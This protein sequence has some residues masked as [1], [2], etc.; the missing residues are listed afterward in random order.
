MTSIRRLEIRVD[1]TGSAKAGIRSIAGSV[2]SIARVGMV[3][4]AAAIGGVA[5]LSGAVLGLGSRLTKLGGSAEEMQAKFDVV[6]GESAP[7]ATRQLNAFGFAVGRNKFAL[8]GMASTLQDTFVPLGFAREKA[9]DMSVAVTKLA[10]DVG[11][12]NNTLAPDVMEDFQSAI[13]GNHETVRKYGIIILQTTLDQE[14]LNMGIEGGVK[15][16]TEMEKVQARLNIIYAGTTDAQGDAIATAGS[17]TNQ[18]LALNESFTEGAT[19]MGLFL[20]ESL[21]PLLSEFSPWVKDLMPKA[22]EIFKEFALNLAGTVF[23]A[24]DLVKDAVV[25]IAEA[26]GAQ[27]EGVSSADVV[28]RAFEMSLGALVTALQLTALAFQAMAALV[29]GA[30]V[31]WGDINRA[32]ARAG[33]TLGMIETITFHALSVAIESIRHAVGTLTLH[34][35]NMKRAALQVAAISLHGLLGGINSIRRALDRVIGYWDRMKDAARRAIDAIPEW[36]RPGSPTP[37]EVGLKGIAQAAKDIDLSMGMAGM[38]KGKR[39]PMAEAG[40]GGGTIVN[41][42]LTYS[43]AISL[44][45]RYELQEKLTPFIMGA[46]RTAGVTP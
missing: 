43:P 20:N 21:L 25:R 24:M 3:A 6:F 41:V 45:D 14:L 34:W 27:T 7:E 32:V 36:L 1:Q 4:G 22:V 12:F 2:G 40:R 23:P 46:L 16:A 35:D 19:E 28:M 9:A 13:V 26:F 11:S 39:G 29:E 18:M 15:V 44:A 31:L 38:G 42:N 37:F 33:V 17:W 5:L 10:V 30:I 8:M